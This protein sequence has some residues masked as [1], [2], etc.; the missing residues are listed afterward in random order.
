MPDAS[1]RE[2]KLEEIMK[3]TG[4]TPIADKQLKILFPVGIIL[5]LIQAFRCHKWFLKRWSDF[6]PAQ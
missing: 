5:F 4:V 1:E 2:P 3:F 6:K